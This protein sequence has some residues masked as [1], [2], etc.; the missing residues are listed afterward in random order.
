MD[1]QQT[2]VSELRRRAHPVQ[3]EPECLIHGTYLSAFLITSRSKP[4]RSIRQLTDWRTRRAS[5]ASGETLPDC[6]A[7]NSTSRLPATTFGS[8]SLVWLP[9]HRLHLNPHTRRCSGSA[10]IPAVHPRRSMKRPSPGKSTSG[11][12]QRRRGTNRLK[13]SK[14]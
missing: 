12:R 5:S 6:L 14:L 13:L 11:C 10:S 3:G 2:S 7:S 1:H 9:N 4:S 8:K